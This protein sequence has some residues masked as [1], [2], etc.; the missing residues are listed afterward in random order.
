MRLYHSPT[1]PFVRKVMVVLHETGQ[2]GDVTLVPAA[3]TAVDPGTMP[4]SLNPLGKIPALERADGPALYDSRVICR[5]LADRAGAALYPP[6]ARQWDTLTLEATADGIMDAGVLMVYE[7]RVRPENLRS[8]DWI[9]GQWA[10]IDRALTVIE[11]RWM[12]H[13]MGALDIGQIAM[14]CA[15]GHLD[16]RHAARNWRQGRGA[17]DDWYA[18]FSLRPSMAATAPVG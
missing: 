18:A 8:T 16:F 6:G 11:N 12:S 1:S 4:L 9:E 17:L 3:G 13:L 14:G 2:L 7:S 15:L 10:K 5:F